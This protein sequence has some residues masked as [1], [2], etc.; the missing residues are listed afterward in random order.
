VRALIFAVALFISASCQAQSSL[1]TGDRA[2]L[3]NRANFRMLNAAT[4]L[5]RDLFQLCADHNG[6]LAAPGEHWN[7]IDVMVGGLP[8]RRV[9]WAARSKE[10]FVVHYEQGGFFHSYHIVVARF[11]PQASSYELSWR[12]EAPRLLA[13]RSHPL[14]ANCSNEVS[15]TAS[16][17]RLPP[18]ESIS[19]CVATARVRTGL[20]PHLD[21]IAP[22]KPG[23]YRLKSTGEIV[24]DTDFLATWEVRQPQQH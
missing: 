10:F 7:P 5:P 15:T 8:S 18:R 23:E 1:S 22:A 14:R 6:L 13:S 2:S 9:I 19:R 4:P 21:A 12:A 20:C 3:E 16:S 24:V 17:S 11:Q